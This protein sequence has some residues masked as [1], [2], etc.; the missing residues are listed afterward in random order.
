MEFEDNIE[1]SDEKPSDYFA[2]VQK[3]FTDNELSEM[4]KQ[5]AI[6]ENFYQLEYDQFLHERRKLM[7]GIIKRAFNKI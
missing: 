5:H 2:M 3:R 1:I 4:L 6:P 7:T